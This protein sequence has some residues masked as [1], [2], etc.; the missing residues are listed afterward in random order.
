M[1]ILKHK[2]KLAVFTTTLIALAVSQTVGAAVIT[3]GGQTATD[4]SGKTSSE[5]SADNTIND[6]SAGFFVETFDRATAIDSL[7]LTADESYNVAGASSGCA[8]NSPLDVTASDASVLNVRKGS[9]RNVAAAP[10]GDSSCYAY[11]TPSTVGVDSFVDIDYTN[12]LNS[13]GSTAPSLAGSSV[14]YLGFYWGSVDTYNS[15]EFYS[16]D[17]LV[18]R[19]TGAELLAELNGTA[20]DQVADSSNVYVNIA[21]DA[22]EA[23]NRLRVVS[24]GI[25]GEFDNIVVGLDKRDVPAPTNLAILGLG[26]LGLG[27]SKRFKK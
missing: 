13:I 23:F 9:S 21:F 12:F 7:P 15:F 26:L 22:S 6:I 11:T 1:K 17:I 4:G 18:S 27:M 25:A 3:F 14:N 20:G 19:I 8:I 24:S 10:A 16:N 5:I 2:N